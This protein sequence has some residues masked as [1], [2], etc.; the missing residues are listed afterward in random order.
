VW[1]TPQLTLLHLQ[2]KGMNQEHESCPSLVN[3]LSRNWSFVRHHSS[4][5]LMSGY[6]LKSWI[7]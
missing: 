2:W 1:E 7:S 5:R 3:T 6:F 4:G